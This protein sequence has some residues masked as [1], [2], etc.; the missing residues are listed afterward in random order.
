M[1]CGAVTQISLQPG[2]HALVGYGS[3]LSIASME[4]TLG[5]TYGQ[6][7]ELVR[8]SGWRRGWD[9]Q[10][11][12]RHWAYTHEGKTVVAERVLYLNVRPAVHDH[13]N[14]ALF[15]VSSEELAAFDAREWIYRREDVSHAIH[16][17]SVTGGTAWMYV[18]LDEYLWRRQSVPPEAVV[19]R[20]YLEILESAH[21][22][23]GDDFRR[24]YDATTDD[25]PQ[26][27]VVDD[28]RV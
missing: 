9:V 25:V 15:V 5:H 28:F 26:H 13:I 23:L 19:R 21:S 4:R 7:F 27:L 3:L 17:V 16:N 1:G 6:P 11:P 18:G 24:E 22:E 14:A 2:E 12:T 8:L 20:S 10:M